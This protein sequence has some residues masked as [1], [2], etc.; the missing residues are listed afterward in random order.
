M[1]SQVAKWG[2]SFALRIPT[3]LARSLKVTEGTRVSLVVEG[4]A[5]VMR[6][7]KERERISLDDLLKGIASENLH[8]ETETGGALGDE[9]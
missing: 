3:S 8:G 4:N 9:F 7:L 6:P 5:L 1:D 2:N